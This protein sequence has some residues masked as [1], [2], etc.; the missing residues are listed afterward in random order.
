MAVEDVAQAGGRDQLVVRVWGQDTQGIAHAFMSTVVAHKCTVLDLSQF[1]LGSSLTFT[2]V[3]DVGPTTN[4]VAMMKDLTKVAK[5]FNLQVDFHASD[6]KAVHSENNPN[7]AVMYLVSSKTFPPALVYDLDG[8]L[9]AHGCAVLSIEH[10]SDNKKENNGEFNK[11]SI[12]FSCPAGFQL[13]ALRTSEHDIVEVAQK[14][15]ADCTVRWWDAMNRPNGKSLVVFGLSNVLYKS[16]VLDEVLTEAGVTPPSPAVGEDFNPE[17]MAKRKVAMLKGI[18]SK[19]IPQVIDRLEFTPGASVVCSALKKMGFRLAV[20][21]NTGVKEIAEHVKRQLGIDYVICRDLE[22]AEDGTFTGEY[23]CETPDVAFRKADLLKLMADREGIEYRNVIVVGDALRG[24]KQSSARLVLETFGP[25][26]YFDA[27]KM[28]NLCIALYLLGFNGSDVQH[29]Q[30]G[31]KR[32]WEMGPGEDETKGNTVVDNLQNHFLI[33][34]SSMSCEPGQLSRILESV[35]KRQAADL[36]IVSI[37]QCSLQSGGMCLGID[38][39]GSTN[40]IAQS[41]G[42]D[43]LYSCQK[44]GFQ[45]HEVGEK[46]SANSGRACWL[47]YMHK[48]HVITLVQQPVIAGDSLTAIFRTLTD[49]GINIL[50]MDRLSV[51]E[52]GAL[53]VTVDL[54]DGVGPDEFSQKLVELSKM[55]GADVAFQKDDL[56]RW[57]RR[58]VI[59]DMDSTLIEGEVIDELAKLA[60]VEEAVSSITKAAM[61]GEINFFESLKQRVALLKGHKA[62]DLF[63][64]VRADLVY[65]PGA[66]KLCCVLKRLGYKMAVISGGFLPMAQVVQRHLGLDYAFA[67]NLETDEH[68]ILT[69]K[70]TGPVVT[71]QRK[72]QLL[73]TIANVEGCDVRQTIAVGDGANDIPMLSTA[74]LGI[75]FCA[76]PK[77]QEA[78]EFRINQKDLSTICYLIGISETAAHRLI[79]QAE[80]S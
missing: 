41:V 34:V 71:P 2:F 42:K 68:G 8:C 45:I 26:V 12:C 60:G 16:D 29:L 48:R 74:G 76:K 65:S 67:N 51:N 78:A 6:G 27:E 73:A 44:H 30:K 4:T 40:A 77:V 59:F 18:D 36:H 14:Y 72:R 1:L 33:T 52:L 15:G 32:K 43:M 53:Q 57:M 38:L 69:G 23:C 20:L 7:V 28:P 9:K 25:Q 21:T 22:V 58:L 35:A 13:S 47:H 49:N 37:R 56:Y 61:R 3:L 54:P 24:L 63:A 75:A 50:K 70:T 19:V 62:E 66:E 64:K 31:L 39:Y 10:R 55:H 17:E 79:E 11:L 46:S 5:D 80:Q